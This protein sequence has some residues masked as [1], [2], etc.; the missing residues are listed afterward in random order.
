VYQGKA[1]PGSAGILARK[2]APA[3]TSILRA[4]RHSAVRD[5]HPGGAAPMGTPRYKRSQQIR[6]LNRKLLYQMILRDGKCNPAV[7]K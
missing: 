1:A 2:R 6:T 7:V 3:R 4:Y 5:G